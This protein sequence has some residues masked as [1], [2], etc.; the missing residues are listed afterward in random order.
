MFQIGD[1]EK[2]VRTAKR[3]LGVKYKNSGSTPFGFDCSGFVMFVYKKNNINL[4]RRVIDQ[5]NSGKRISLRYAK[6]GDLVFFKIYSHK[7]SHV[8]I[9]IDKNIFIH[10]PK[11]GRRVSYAKINNNY[12]KKRYAG[13]V[14]YLKK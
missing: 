13:T 3:Y 11:K 7:I 10:S 12:W 4:P 14:T 9:Y 8:G 1:R 5:F 6:P 2:I